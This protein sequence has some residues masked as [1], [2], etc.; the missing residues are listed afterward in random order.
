MCVGITVQAKKQQGPAGRIKPLSVDDPVVRWGKD[1]ERLRG[2]PEFH[3]ERLN[4]YWKLLRE[5]KG[6]WTMV[7]IDECLGAIPVTPSHLAGTKSGRCDSQHPSSSQLGP[8]CVKPQGPPPPAPFRWHGKSP[9]SL[10][11]DVNHSAKGTGCDYVSEKDIVGCVSN[12]AFKGWGDFGSE[13]R[14]NALDGRPCEVR[15]HHDTQRE[16]LFSLLPSTPSTPPPAFTMLCIPMSSVTTGSR[17]DFDLF[18]RSNNAPLAVK[19]NTC[20]IAQSAGMDT[21]DI[22]PD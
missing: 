6:C 11:S 15:W 1:K 3:L 13:R 2:E 18:S 21:E 17:F 14:G 8:Y 20:A 5:P 9:M 12:V 16:R 10:F 19:G 4:G 22:I 7:E